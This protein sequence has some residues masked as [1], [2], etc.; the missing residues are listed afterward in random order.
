MGLRKGV[1]VGGYN[2]KQENILLYFFSNHN[3]WYDN[4]GS[5]WIK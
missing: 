5:K 1:I 2:K 3:S 4:D